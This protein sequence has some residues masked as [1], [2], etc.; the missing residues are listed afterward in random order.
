MGEGRW[1]CLPAPAPTG[2]CTGCRWCRSPAGVLHLAA[3]RVT[4]A[5]STRSLCATK[6]Q[7]A[8]PK[9]I[10]LRCAAAAAASKRRSV[11]PSPA[12]CIRHC[13]PR[14]CPQR[15]SGAPLA[16][17]RAEL[18]VQQLD[19]APR[20]P[21]ARGHGWLRCAGHLFGAWWDAMQE[22]QG[23]L[24]GG[25]GK[26][27][28]SPSASLSRAV[29]RWR[30]WEVGAGEAGRLHMHM[31]ACSAPCVLAQLPLP[32]CSA[33]PPAHP[34]TL[35][36]QACILF[37][38]GLIVVT[39]QLITQLLCNQVGE[40]ARRCHTMCGRAQPC[41]RAPSAQHAHRVGPGGRLRR[42]HP[43]L[44]WAPPLLF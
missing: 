31:N 41:E 4:P 16:T 15:T 44:T 28:I 10:L 43:A 9:C 22:L 30:A 23:Q 27:R 3:S 5:T 14:R 7:Q 13:N 1:G 11:R 36:P 34:P 29:G 21:C 38:L 25:A 42:P 32:L 24:Q 17:Q 8:P 18:P 39:V 12:P 26:G 35:L 37:G 2:V 33:R 6:L 20:L 19:S 40:F